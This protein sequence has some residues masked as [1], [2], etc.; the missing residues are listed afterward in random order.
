MGLPGPGPLLP[1]V[2][3]RFASFS[4]AG[5]GDVS[6]AFEARQTEA[7]ARRFLPEVKVER[8]RGAGE[9]PFG[10]TE[11]WSLGYKYRR[12]LPRT[13]LPAPSAVHLPPCVRR[14]KP[15]ARSCLRRLGF[16]RTF[17]LAFARHVDKCRLS[18][19]GQ[20]KAE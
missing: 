17:P 6:A 10:L 2:G 20:G 8:E 13:L 16:A 14:S 1:F 18:G 11:A 4:A 12:G 5:R 19:E 15:S 7:C 9:V 3:R